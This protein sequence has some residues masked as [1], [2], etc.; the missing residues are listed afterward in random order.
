MA[1]RLGCDILKREKAGHKV[2]D[3]ALMQ[4]GKSGNRRRLRLSDEDLE[5]WKRRNKAVEA[6]ERTQ[7]RRLGAWL[8]E[9]LRSEGELGDGASVAS[10]CWYTCRSSLVPP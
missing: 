1:K 4:N 5:E 6:W 8:A 2:S 7:L 3:G 9:L 10:P